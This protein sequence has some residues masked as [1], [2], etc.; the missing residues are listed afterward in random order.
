MNGAGIRLFAA[1]RDAAVKE[2]G[3]D[4]SCTQALERAAHGDG[5]AIAATAQDEMRRLDQNVMSRLMGIAHQTL[6]LDPAA[7]LEQWR[8]GSAGPAD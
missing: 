1:L 4:H 6:R 3:R 5:P 7:I 8:G 2:L